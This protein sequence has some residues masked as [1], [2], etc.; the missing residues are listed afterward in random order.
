[1][2]AAT[3]DGVFAT[4]MLGIVEIFGIAGAVS[5]EVPSAPISLLGPLP[6]WLGALLQLVLGLL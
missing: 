6:L 4:I 2:V 3:Y 5:L 1:M